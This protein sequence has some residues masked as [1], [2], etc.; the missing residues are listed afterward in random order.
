MHLLGNLKW[1]GRAMIG[2]QDEEQECKHKSDFFN[3]EI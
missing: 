2:T 1:S 3:Q